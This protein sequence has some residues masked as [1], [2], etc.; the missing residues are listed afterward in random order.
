MKKFIESF[1]FY[2][3]ISTL[4]FFS[5]YL[6]SG[7]IY[8]YK[9]KKYE[10]IIDGLLWSRAEALNNQQY[11]HRILRNDPYLISTLADLYMINDALSEYKLENGVYPY[12]SYDSWKSLPKKNVWIPGLFPK[13]LL[14]LPIDNR[15]SLDENLHYKYVSDGTVYKLISHGFQSC[16]DIKI[17]LPEIVDPL[18]DCWAIGFWSTNGEN[19]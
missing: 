7:Q 3:L 4:L 12:S 17:L 2:T 8:N 11:Y 10:V 16:N 13:Y 6:I 5:A 1:A 15:Q 19:L 14:R 9:H 18:R